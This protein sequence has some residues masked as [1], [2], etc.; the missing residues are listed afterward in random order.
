MGKHVRNT[1]MLLLLLKK[2]VE[3]SI[4]FRN[5]FNNQH[6]LDCMVI[7]FNQFEHFIYYQNVNQRSDNKINL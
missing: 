2:K 6:I 4:Y 7:Y 1:M 3:I 5:I